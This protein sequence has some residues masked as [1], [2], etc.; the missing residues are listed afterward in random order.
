MRFRSL[1][2]NGGSREAKKHG[3]ADAHLLASTAQL[4]F[5]AA[6]TDVDPRHRLA[7]ATELAARLRALPARRAQHAVESVRAQQSGQPPKPQNPKDSGQN[8]NDGSQVIVLADGSLLRVTK[9]D[10]PDLFHALPWSHGTLG[11][12]VGL[13]LQIIPDRKSV[14]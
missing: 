13:E 11:L 1:A 2:A 12:L 8:R 10:H 14:V 4:L 3:E 7:S 5:L 6:A 9:D